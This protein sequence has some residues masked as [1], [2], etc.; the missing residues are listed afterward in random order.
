[1]FGVI[2]VSSSSS[3]YLTKVI[4]RT[5]EV[6]LRPL[7]YRGIISFLKKKKLPIIDMGFSKLCNYLLA[8]FPTI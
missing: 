7:G 2:Y 8:K 5:S 4:F 6:K 1:L 3:F